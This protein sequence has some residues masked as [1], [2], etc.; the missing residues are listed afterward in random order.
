LFR[1]Y[2]FLIFLLCI[3][4]SIGQ[5]KICGQIDT[6]S[7][8]CYSKEKFPASIF[9]I[10]KKLESVGNVFSNE[11]S[12]LADM[13]GD[14]I[15]ELIAPDN[16]DYKIHIIDSRTGLTKWEINTPFCYFRSG[17]AIA[18]IDNDGIPEI[19]LRTATANFPANLLGKL[20]CYNANG[21]IRWISD[22]K[23]YLDPKNELAGKLA[24]ADFNQDGVPEIY[25][26]NIIFNAQTGIK[27]AD[28][29]S[30]GKGT[31]DNSFDAITIAAQLD[32]D[33][34]DLELAAGY[35]IY[36]VKITNPNGTIGNTLTPINIRVNFNY[37]DGYTTV[38]DIDLDGNLDVVVT[39][40]GS[41]HSILVYTYTL[42]NGSSKLIAQ[43][44][45]GGSELDIGPPLV[46]DINNSGKPSILFMTDEVLHAYSYNG[47]FILQNDWAQ[48]TTDSSG[49]IGLTLFDFNNDGIKEIVYRD[50]TGLNIINGQSKPPKLLAQ[51]PCYA[52]TYYEYPIV[53][54][55][56]NSGHAKI[57]V[58]C[59]SNIYTG[60]GK[61]TVFGAPDSLP[62][63]APAR[64]VWNQ[65]NYHVLNINDDL[66]IPRVEKN[67]A[68]YKNGKYNN[69]YVQESLLDSNGMYLHK[70]AS[71]TGKIKSVTYD[72]INDQYTVVFDLYNRADA[73]ARADS[74]LPVPFYNGDPANSGILIGSYYTLKKIEPGDSLLN[75]IY[76]F[77]AN[78]LSDLFM[79]INTIR[80]KT[81]AFDPVD[82][83]ISEC[84]YTDNTFHT[85]VLPKN[86]KVNTC[87]VSTIDTNLCYIKEKF[88]ITKFAITEKLRS[89][90]L[91]S[92][93]QPV[94]LADMDGDCI[95]EFI[96]TGENYGGLK[97]DQIFIIDSKTGI[98]KW[99]FITPPIDFDLAG[100][101]VAD[102]NGDGIP[103]IFLETRIAIDSPANG[104]ARLYCYSARGNLI[105]VSDQTV[106]DT[107]NPRDEIAGGTPALADFNQDGIP[108]IYV[109]N[110]IFNARTGVK[111]AGGGANGLGKDVQPGFYPDALSIAA[112][113]DNDPSDLELAAGY[114]I[115]KVK[116]INPNGMNGNSMTPYNI[117]IDNTFKDG[118]TT[119]GDIDSDGKLDVV[120]TSPG[121]VGLLYAYRLFNGSP[122]L[123]AK[124]Y[125]GNTK[126]HM[127]PAFIGDIKG[128]GKPSILFTR[129]KELNSYSYDGTTTFKRDWSLFTTDNSGVTGVTMFDFN[130]DGIQEIVYRDETE[131]RV[132]DGSTIPPIVL[133]SN[134][135]YGAT[136]SEYPIVGDLDLSGHAKICIPCADR[137]TDPKGLL[138]DLVGKLIVFGAPSNLPGWAP[139][140][141]IWNQYNYHVLNINDD[142]TVPRVEKN[143]A[144]YKNGKYNNFYVQESLLDSNGM[145]VKRA[146][147]LTGKIKCINY[148]PLNNEYNVIFDIY[149][150]I[151]ASFNADSS[152]PVSFYNGD[153]ATGGILIGTDKTLKRL[154]S[155]DSLLNLEFKFTLSNITDLFMVVN[156]KR[157][158]SGQFNQADFS[159]PECDYTDNTFHTLDLPRI[160]ILNASICKGEEYNFF[161]TLIHDAGVYYN[162]LTAI[163]GCDSLVSTLKLTTVDSVHASQT[164]QACDKYNW[165]GRTYMHSGTFIH[166]TLNSFGC[167]SITTLELVINNSD[168]INTLHTACDSFNWN[169][170]TYIKS[171]I[172]SYQSVNM[173]GCDSI[174]ALAL[175]INKSDN[176]LINQTACNN[177]FWNGQTYSQSG[178]YQFDTINR[179]G[180]D[181]TVT[182]NL[183]IN[184][185]INVSILDAGCDS[186]TWNGNTYTQSGSYQFKTINQQDCDSITTL[187]LT[188]YKTSNSNSALT[189]CDSIT[190]NGITYS[191]SGNYQYKTINAVG[192]D[193]IATL[194]LTIIKSSTSNTATRACNSFTWNG[195]TYNQ[196]GS[197]QYTTQNSKGCDSIA[198]LNLIINSSDSL[199]LNQSACDR[200]TWNGNTYN[201]SGSY[202]YQTLNSSGCDSILNLNLTIR[203]SSR[204]DI[205]LS[206]CDSLAFLG[207]ILKA[208]GNYN[209]LL[210]NADGCDSVINLSL[211]IRS[212]VYNNSVSTCVPFTWIVNGKTYNLS[213]VYLEKYT[214]SFGCDSIF[215]L[216]LNI[217]KSFELIQQAEV[218]KEYFWP[219]NKTVLSQSGEYSYP[220]KTNQGC[221]SIIKLDLIVNHD[222]EKTD[223]VITDTTYTW[224]INHQTYPISGT[225]QE[226][227]TSTGGCDSI[228]ILFLIIKKDVGIYYPNVIHP[229]GINGWFTLFDNG[230]T[231]SL[232]TSLS[233]FD[234]WGELVW[235]KH[236]FPANDLQLGWNGTFQDQNVLPGV[237]VWLAQITLQDGTAIFKKGDL[238]VIK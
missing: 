233:I 185:I 98:T 188:I 238:T 186:Y 218:C 69:F 30:N 196:S 179:F 224:P 73:S 70:A 85:L 17:M 195:V 229:G 71:L 33:S 97:W 187:Q 169:G 168:A 212:E 132:I 12:L 64:G 78:N 8:L 104:G 152:M 74:N 144:T 171:G 150:R 86:H 128:V 67:N 198:T 155:G 29:G 81:G 146:A 62:G 126:P 211:N 167:D 157:D 139:A 125:V 48:V 108:E 119:V 16:N 193:S 165:N 176:Q 172:Y 209:F 137:P 159:I 5:V 66:T 180:C 6:S 15:P 153:P 96:V 14:C 63:W 161:G 214:N 34:T 7:S 112:Q 109:N 232:I 216:D 138:I 133:S 220:L 55:I 102:I 82:F 114:T 11:I 20:I 208:N 115:Y 160:E 206:V 162:K 77:Y 3:Q 42:S 174:T 10:E 13:D 50:M 27:L 219:V 1:F 145:Y 35:T 51:I 37:R 158:T 170:K 210:K 136:R 23:Y 89:K 24:L 43:A 177:Y 65:Y 148:D 72:S 59:S 141:G 45:F 60:D 54:D 130:N 90:D 68:T 25:I 223:T 4:P 236:D 123:I 87:H 19:F 203:K 228:H 166:D 61:L 103:E 88:P 140:R 175:T 38:A 9:A 192:C 83:T 52:G 80:N 226:H 92:G 111:L 205:A 21:S 147:S 230:N 75:L 202:Q 39:S 121:V 151:D 32:E 101:A 154:E 127:G 184:S 91:V 79:V 22:Q 222:F 18:D 117:Q 225:Y 142:L 49:S 2:I 237:Y 57:C 197:Y 235:H 178:S 173:F 106:N 135:C 181:S 46:G 122:Q 26:S 131:L 95:P 183:T 189:T 118:F 231:I 234:R 215:I 40:Q 47:S 201:Q 76:K 221:D 194:Q 94:L 190:W 116:I 200:Y 182:L 110:K 120:V 163:S 84:D 204:A 113:L 105:W 129:V 56:D 124:A 207:Q 199:Q 143:N 191:Q 41:T 44:S 213:G 53:G 149:N 93:N 134:S 31:D 99:S 156:T 227:F 58:P 100:L 164:I 107:N 28:G 217:L 36:K